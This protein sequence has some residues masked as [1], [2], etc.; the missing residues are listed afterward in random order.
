MSNESPNLEP[1]NK[2]FG[3]IKHICFSGRKKNSE[4]NKQR[5][6]KKR[7]TNTRCENTVP[8]FGQFCPLKVSAVQ[9]QV[10]NIAVPK[11]SA[12]KEKKEEQQEKNSFA[13]DSPVFKD[14]SSLSGAINT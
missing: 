7:N 4:N 1:M 2:R 12:M 5:N 11:S 9:Q 3:F 13:Y 14:T 10:K 8:G 6:E